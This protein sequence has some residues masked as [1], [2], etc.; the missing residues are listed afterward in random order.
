MILP[1]LGKCTRL[2]RG[3]R[4]G[5]RI[6]GLELVVSGRLSNQNSWT[7]SFNYR[8]VFTSRT[9][10][11]SKTS[12]MT[13][14][15]SRRQRAL[16]VRFTTAI[17]LVVVAQQRQKQHYLRMW[18]RTL[19]PIMSPEPRYTVVFPSLYLSSTPLHRERGRI[20]SIITQFSRLL[21]VESR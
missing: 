13:P 5:K 11:S 2:K 10:A 17:I 14:I 16:Q 8:R 1:P 7:R 9:L 21:R 3:N 19:V 6:A 18:Q 4:N 20:Y 15:K 12:L